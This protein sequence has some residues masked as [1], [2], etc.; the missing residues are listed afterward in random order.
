MNLCVFKV[1]WTFLIGMFPLPNLTTPLNCLSDASRGFADSSSL[2]P[3]VIP[4]V[5][6]V[7]DATLNY[8]LIVRPA[9][10]LDIPKDLLAKMLANIAIS[11]AFGSVGYAFFERFD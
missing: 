1:G 6:D 5:G 7:V 3:G 4:G 2:Y 11:A 10:E 9:T 8:T